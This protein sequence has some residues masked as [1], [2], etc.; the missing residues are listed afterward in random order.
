MKLVSKILLVILLPGLFVARLALP[1]TST[2]PVNFPEP[3]QVAVSVDPLP[4]SIYCPGAFAE[5]GGESGVEIGAIDRIGT[6][7]IWLQQGVGQ[8]LTD[9]G[10]ATNTGSLAVISGSPQSTGLLSAIQTQGVSRDRADGLLASY[11]PQ[12][13]YS[14]WFVNGST[15]VGQE[16]VLLI[17]NPNDLEVQLTLVIDLGDKEISQQ[18]T[19]AA[20][21]I[22]VVPLATLALLN[23]A[24]TVRY[25]TSGQP[26]S[27]AMQQRST[28]GLNSRGLSLLTPMAEP[29]TDS[30]ISGLSIKAV[31]FEPTVA[32]IYNP[33]QLPTEVVIT[34]ISSQFTKVFR[35]NLDAGELSEIELDLENGDYFLLVQAGQPVLAA[36]KNSV[37]LPAIDFSWL[38]QSELFTDLSLPVPDYSTTLF[39]TNPGANAISINL[40]VTGSQGPQYQSL[41]LP[42]LSQV[43]IPVAGDS[44]RITASGEFGAALELLDVPGYAVIS[45]SENVNFGDELSVSVR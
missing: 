10:L 22:R 24:F 6:A 19:L 34:A 12:P 17:S 7:S 1:D 29:A 9:P 39:I 41:E 15:A 13:S 16:S 38:N 23:P 3:E 4:L 20:E 18:L 32:R 8:L 31:G 30:L 33:S 40:R 25:Q 27:I 11:C 21:E 43:G 45:A 5:V 2:E 44:L 14:G 42:A 37:L 35:Q 26:I 28:F 36:V